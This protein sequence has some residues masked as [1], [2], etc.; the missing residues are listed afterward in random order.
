[1]KILPGQVSFEWDKGNID[2]N[3]VKHHVANK[4]AEEV[5]ESEPKFVIEDKKHLLVEKRFQL[6]GTTSKKRKLSIIFTLRDK[7]I[8]IISARDMNRK[9][10]RAYEKE[11]EAHTKI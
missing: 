9:E 10:R 6:W 1:M 5:F 4:E 11:I 2:K 7:K 8:R 3:L